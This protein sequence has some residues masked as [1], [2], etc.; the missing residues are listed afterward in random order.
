MNNKIIE[1]L[2]SCLASL[3]RIGESDKEIAMLTEIRLQMELE[4]ARETLIK[5]YGEIDETQEKLNKATEEIVYMKQALW[6]L[7]KKYPEEDIDWAMKDNGD[8]A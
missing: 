3:S 5:V 6:S 4:I 1:T 7:K 8:K 2:K